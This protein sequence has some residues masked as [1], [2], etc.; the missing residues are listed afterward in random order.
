[1]HTCASGRRTRSRRAPD[2]HEHHT[3]FT[4]WTSLGPIEEHSLTAQ[5]RRHRLRHL[6]PQGGFMGS[7]RRIAGICAVVAGTLG[8]ASIPVA[9]AAPAAGG[10]QTGNTTGLCALGNGA[11]KIKH[12]IYLQF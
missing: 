3:S 4:R 10:S 1:M 8:L 5:T 11:G 7:I 2:E 9:S 12:V 6:T